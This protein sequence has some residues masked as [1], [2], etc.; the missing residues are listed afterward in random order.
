MKIWS[1]NPAE[2][3]KDGFDP[4]RAVLSVMILMIGIQK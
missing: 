1:S 2:S 4:K 3:S